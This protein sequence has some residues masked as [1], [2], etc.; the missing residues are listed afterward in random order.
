MWVYPHFWY[1]SDDEAE[2]E[3]NWAETE[4]RLFEQ[5]DRIDAAAARLRAG[6]PGRPDVFF[7][8]FAGVAE[9][10]VF[11]EELKLSEQRRHANATPPRDARC[12]SS[13]IGATATAGRSPPCTGCD[14]RSSGRA[15]AWTATRTCCS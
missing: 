6:A 2:E 10:K 13:T 11:A 15:S 7:V 4:R 9:Q 5:A 1:A 14:A 12:C 8:G 3:E